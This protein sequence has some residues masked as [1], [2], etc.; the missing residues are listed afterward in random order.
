MIKIKPGKLYTLT[1][2][3]VFVTLNG[4]NKI[5]CIYPFKKNTVLLAVSKMQKTISR[6]YF[7]HARNMYHQHSYRFLIN[8]TIVDF[9]LSDSTGKE[10]N[11]RLDGCIKP[12]KK[13]KNG[14]L[15]E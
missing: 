13:S 4:E 2:D 7:K 8:D 12:L 11:R 6:F 14:I 5:D 1:K 9:I 3:T 15:N 10:L